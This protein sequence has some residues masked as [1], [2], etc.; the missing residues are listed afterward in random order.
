MRGISFTEHWK[1]W[2]NNHWGWG[3]FNFNGSVWAPASLRPGAIFT[4]GILGGAPAQNVVSH[5][6]PP[7]V[8]NFSSTTTSDTPGRVPNAIMCLKHWF[9][10]TYLRP[11]CSASAMWSVS[12]MTN[13]ASAWGWCCRHVCWFRH[14]ASRCR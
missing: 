3:Y 1:H 14:R 5:W 4:S 7:D 12:C 2:R 13:R 6:A 9:G 10:W 11:D 8:R